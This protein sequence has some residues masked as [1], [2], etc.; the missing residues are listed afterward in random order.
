MNLFVTPHVCTLLNKMT[1]QNENRN[2]HI[3]ETICALLLGAHVPIPR[4]T[5]VV[6]I[7]TYLINQMLSKVHE[8]N[9]SL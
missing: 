6:T 9:A 5:D 1:L 3:L 8:F 4:W 7:A 2:C